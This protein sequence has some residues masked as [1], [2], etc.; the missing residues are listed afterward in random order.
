MGTCEAW[1]G[2][3]VGLV[4]PGLGLIGVGWVCW[5][6]LVRVGGYGSGSRDCVWLPP[7]WLAGRL[8]PSDWMCFLGGDG[9]SAGRL[10][11]WRLSVG[12]GSMSGLGWTQSGWLGPAGWFPLDSWP[13]G[14]LADMGL[15]GLGLVRVVQGWLGP[16]G[17]SGLGLGGGRMV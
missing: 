15:L 2:A 17:L 14:F 9:G 6:W 13:V 5:G 11:G 16:I 10:V 7:G 12:V 4:R 1:V 8:F 3:G